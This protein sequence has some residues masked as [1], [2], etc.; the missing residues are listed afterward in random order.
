VVYTIVCHILEGVDFL[1][2]LRLTE[3]CLP[4]EVECLPLN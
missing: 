4:K 3:V 1:H 2:C